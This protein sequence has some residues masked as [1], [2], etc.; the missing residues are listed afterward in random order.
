MANAVL[1]KSSSTASAVPAAGSLAVR[2]LALNTADGRLFT[3]TGAG[4]VVEFARKDVED[5]QRV[6]VD[7]FGF[8]NQTETTL[9]FVDATST[10]TVAPVG[11][12]W[13]Y[14]RS[15]VKCTITGAKSVVLPAASSTTIIY[16]I[17]I[18]ATDGSLTYSTTAWTLKDSKVPVAT[19]ARCT[20]STPTY[21]VAE[22]RHT[23]LIPRRTHLYLHATRGTVY[24]SGAALTGPTVG[25]STNSAK[26]CAVATCS[27]FDEDINDVTSAIA[28]GNGSTD[29]FYSISYRNTASNWVWTR[30]V[31]PFK[32]TGAAAIEW[33]NNGTMTAAG[34]GAG[35]NT[36]WVNYY[37]LCNN[38]A[39]QESVMWV[40]GRAAFTS[41][42]AAYGES[43]AD[44]SITGFPSVEAVAIYQFTWATSGSGLG[45]CV[46]ARTPE[47]INSNILTSTAIAVGTH[48]SLAGLQGGAIDDYQHLTAAQLAVVAATSGTNTGDNAANTT[49][50][51]DY[52]AANFVAGTNYLA[53]NGS[54][55]AL[56]GLTS[57]QVTTALGYTPSNPGGLSVSII[58][59]NT[60]ASAGTMYVLTAS[61]TLTLPAS[62][63]IGNTVNI[64][65]RS[66][67]A[68]CV[69]GRNAQP[70]MSLAED[71]TLDIAESLTL[72]YT[73][74][75][76]GWVLL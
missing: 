9:G 60:T 22:E 66:G 40:P 70:I 24:Q 33:D 75:T 73:D 2:E 5:A 19:V 36:R 50:A 20:A 41:A 39:G 69:V 64:A 72:V 34:S 56:T 71:M 43:F 25:S 32:Y 54:A 30:S 8:L 14:Y 11:A 57:T 46:L 65:N 48:N 29:T 55:A 6:D 62:P 28:A 47:R 13:S 44:F 52:R 26:T 23:C 38:V 27:I 4:A 68:T 49:Y 7:L 16:F 51:S 18:D 76:R 67:V 59:T 21:L 3:K 37:M 53:P 74:A 1:H 61:L 10:F 45:L 17:Y 35:G 31:M 58:S 15:G 63:T 42:A 12:S